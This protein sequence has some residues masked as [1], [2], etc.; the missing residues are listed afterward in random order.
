M[1]SRRG[2]S[3]VP[4]LTEEDYIKSGGADI[5]INDIALHDVAVHKWHLNHDFLNTESI[6]FQR[7]RGI[8]I[9]TRNI[10]LAIKADIVFIQQGTEL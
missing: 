1:F 5:D 6:Y 10:L 8:A 9:M 3:S 2:L 4:R 7:L